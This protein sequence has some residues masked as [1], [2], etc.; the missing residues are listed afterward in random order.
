MAEESRSPLE[1]GLNLSSLDGVPVAVK[2]LLLT[3]DWPTR[4]GSLTIDPSGPWTEDAPCVARLKEAGAVLIGKTTTPEF[5]WKGSTDSPL[6]GITRNPWNE[7]EDNAG[8]SS[9]GLSV[10]LAARMAPLALGTDGGGS[11]RIPASFVRCLWAEVELRAGVGL[12]RCRH[13]EQSCICRPHE[14]NRARRRFTHERHCTA[15]GP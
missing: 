13:L 5:G 9:G 3:S 14:P 4:R 15:R 10:A 2:D 11:I 6:T 7:D 12:V 1:F 8:G